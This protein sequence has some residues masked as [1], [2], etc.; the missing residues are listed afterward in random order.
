MPTFTEAFLNQL[1]S[2]MDVNIFRPKPWETLWAARRR[3]V[4]QWDATEM[5][6]VQDTY[7]TVY[8]EEDDT[9]ATALLP[10]L[11]KTAN[12]AWEYET[13]TGYTLLIGYDDTDFSILCT[14]A[15]INVTNMTGSIAGLTKTGVGENDSYNESVNADGT[16]ELVPT[17]DA[18]I[19]AAM[20]AIAY[21]HQI[22]ATQ[23]DIL[24]TGPHSPHDL[25]LEA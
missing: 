19:C 14:A 1:N 5:H 18:D 15:S 8:D 24:P 10:N 23:L 2:V 13:P 3:P 12:N 22:D 6:P 7:K 11:T 25:D 20:I 4:G 21:G 17:S 9:T 16:T